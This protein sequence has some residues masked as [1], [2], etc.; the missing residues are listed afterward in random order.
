MFQ[1]RRLLQRFSKFVLAPVPGG[2][3]LTNSPIGA[4]LT[5]DAALATQVSEI[6]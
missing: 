1:T 5:A 2:A 4:T 3:L 6:N